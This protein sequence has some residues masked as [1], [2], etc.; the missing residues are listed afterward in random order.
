MAHMYTNVESPGIYYGYR[1]Q[2]TSWI[3][4]SDATCHTTTYILDIIRGSLMEI[5][6]YI[7]ASDGHFVTAK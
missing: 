2:L 4:E 1:L 6:K 3:L 5:D 7:E